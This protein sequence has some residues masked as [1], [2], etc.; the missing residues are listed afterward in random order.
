MTT[1]YQ[2]ETD[3]ESEVYLL[4]HYRD[5][6]LLVDVRVGD[7]D[8][9]NELAMSE[10]LVLPKGEELRISDGKNDLVSGIR[11]YQTYGRGNND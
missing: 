6:A 1:M 9:L 4:M 11:N 10:A 3:G 8:E 7:F 5:N 2:P